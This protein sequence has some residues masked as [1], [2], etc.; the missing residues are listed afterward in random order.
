[1]SRLGGGNKLLVSQRRRLCRLCR[2]PCHCVETEGTEKQNCELQSVRLLA[3]TEEDEPEVSGSS[4][5]EN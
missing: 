4:H 1:M 5:R 3:T 2:L